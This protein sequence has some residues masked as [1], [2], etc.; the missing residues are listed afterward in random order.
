MLNYGIY[1][2]YFCFTDDEVKKLCSKNNTLDY[3]ELKEWYNCYTTNTGKNIYNPR[4]VVCALEDEVC[5][6]Y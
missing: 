1:S 2:D 6:S 5:R 3:L 4:S